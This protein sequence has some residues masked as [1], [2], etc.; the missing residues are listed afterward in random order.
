MENS[1][2]GSYKR[3]E[4]VPVEPNASQADRKTLQMVD[5]KDGVVS[6]KET[7]REEPIVLGL[8]EKMTPEQSGRGGK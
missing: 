7:P 5:L 2:F 6:Y 4:F 3:P 8:N 1:T